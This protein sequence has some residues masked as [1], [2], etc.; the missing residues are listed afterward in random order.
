MENLSNLIGPVTKVFIHG[1]FIYYVKSTDDKL[2]WYNYAGEQMGSIQGE[3]FVIIKLLLDVLT[4]YYCTP[5]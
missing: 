3:Y 2:F 5:P 4:I 1:D